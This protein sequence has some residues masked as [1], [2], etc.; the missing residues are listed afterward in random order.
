MVIN[1]SK[2][3]RDYEERSIFNFLV[4]KMCIESLNTVY[5]FL[6]KAKKLFFL[7]GQKSFQKPGLLL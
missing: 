4:L 5:W 1:D 3:D 2:K 7:F 6:C